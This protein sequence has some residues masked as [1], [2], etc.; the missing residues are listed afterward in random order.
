MARFT[1]RQQKKFDRVLHEYKTH[2]L[3]SGSKQGPLVKKRGQAIAIA[4]AEARSLRK[5]RQGRR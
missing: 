1:P 3:H 5:R 4:F 2:S